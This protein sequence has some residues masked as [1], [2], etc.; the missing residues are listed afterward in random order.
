MPPRDPR[1]GTLTD[2]DLQAFESILGGGGVVTDPH[3]LQPY[4]RCVCARAPS[5]TPVA[6]AAG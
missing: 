2:A 6:L 5:L 1:F 3:A 4:I